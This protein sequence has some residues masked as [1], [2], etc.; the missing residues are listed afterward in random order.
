MVLMVKKEPLV[1][2]VHLAPRAPLDQE[3][4]MDPVVMMPLMVKMA[5]QVRHVLAKV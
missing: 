4:A 2:M 3:V 5:H 1:Q